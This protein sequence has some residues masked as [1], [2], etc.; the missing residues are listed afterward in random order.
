MVKVAVK[1]DLKG[2]EKKVSPQNFKRGQM[3]MANQM[4]MDMNKYVPER[5]GALR[6]SGHA[7]QDRVIW[8]TVYA[9]IVFYGRRRKGFF[10]DRQ[11]RYFFA[12][13]ERLLAQKPR[14]GTGPRWDKKAT[15]KHSKEWARVALKGMGLL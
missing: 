7:A 12:N 15:P 9:R 3:A 8:S 5:S 6:A 1:V 14:A 4:L 2:L 13:K 11:R 10:S